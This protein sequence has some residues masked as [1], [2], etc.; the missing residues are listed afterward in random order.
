MNLVSNAV[1]FTESG[2]V[3]I[4][5]AARERE[6]AIRIT[7]ADTGVGIEAGHLDT[8]FEDFRQLDQSTTKRHGGTGLGLSITRK[9]VTLLGGSIG[10]ESERGRGSRFTVEL[11]LITDPTVDDPSKR[12][13]FDALARVERTATGRDA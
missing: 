9:L 8:I 2:S 10:V 3:R 5:V 6:E 1:K 4:R 13:L 7:V 11:P 12:A